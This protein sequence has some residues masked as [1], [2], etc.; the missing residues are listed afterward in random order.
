L[1]KR[2]NSVL[3]F[4][5]YLDKDTYPAD[6]NFNFTKFQLPQTIE[7]ASVATFHE[8]ESSIIRNFKKRMI[9]LRLEIL[10]S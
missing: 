1:T 7:S 5:E 10:K 3:K 2:T 8:A 4:Q 6:L 9:E